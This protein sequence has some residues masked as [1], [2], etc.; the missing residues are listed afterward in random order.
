MDGLTKYRELNM[1]SHITHNDI[2][3]TQVYIAV[4]EINQYKSHYL[5]LTSIWF[6]KRFHVKVFPSVQ[7]CGMLLVTIS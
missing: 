7:S 3:P 2:K 5:H 1:Y 4:C 6:P